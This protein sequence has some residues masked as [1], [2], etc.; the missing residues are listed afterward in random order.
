[1]QTVLSALRAWFKECA[2]R[3]RA[4]WGVVRHGVPE[5]VPATPPPPPEPLPP[6]APHCLPNMGHKVTREYPLGTVIAVISLGSGALARQ[7]YDAH[8]AERVGEWICYYRHNERCG[9]KTMVT[10]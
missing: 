6:V 3:C 9:A 4:A 1:M 8:N 10:P 2:A 5:P 7:A